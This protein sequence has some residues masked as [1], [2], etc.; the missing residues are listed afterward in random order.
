MIF[1]IQFYKIH[2]KLKNLY[3][4]VISYFLNLEHQV[5][6][7]NMLLVGP[8]SLTISLITAFFVSIVF[9][10]QTAKEFLYLNASSL[11]GSILTVSFLRELSPVLTS[12]IVIGRIG[13]SFTAELATM[14]VTEQIDALYL[15][16]TDPLLYLVFPRVIAC[17]FMLP[18]LNFL[19]FA[20]SMATSAFICFTLYAVDP[21]IFLSSSF[22]SL[23]FSDIIKSLLKT[24]IFGFAIACISCYFG[25]LTK[26]GARGV[27]E[28]TTVSVVTSLLLIFILDFVLSYCMFDK[29]NSSIKNL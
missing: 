28:S 15:L 25:L 5:V 3:K 11:L 29:L 23:L 27:G 8:G 7:E 16:N 10:L 22:S 24:V 6:V 12:V 20:T 21:V 17:V 26:G 9:T 4:I 18:L 1:K 2:K 14:K 13:S 19:S